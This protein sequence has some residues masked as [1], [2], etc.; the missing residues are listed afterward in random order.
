MHFLEIMK[1]WPYIEGENKTYQQATVYR[2][3]FGRISREKEPYI[4]GGVIRIS[5]EI[6]PFK[7][8]FGAV[9]KLRNTRARF[10]K[11]FLTDFN[12]P[13]GE[14]PFSIPP[15]AEASPI[16]QGKPSAFGFTQ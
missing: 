8:I 3:G 10:N 14:S 13:K 1:N 9:S 15:E 5:R 4:E 16:P 11:S 2:G 7:A 12:S 6:T